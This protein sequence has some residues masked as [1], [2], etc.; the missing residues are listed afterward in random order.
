MATYKE[1]RCEICN[2]IFIPT[3]GNQKVCHKCIPIRKK[4]YISK[5]DKEQHIKKQLSKGLGKPQTCPICGNTF[6][7]LD[8][9]KIYCGSV[10]CE[11]MRCKLKNKRAQ[12]IRNKKRKKE[13]INKLKH[14]LFKTYNTEEFTGIVKIKSPTTHNMMYTQEYVEYCFSKYGYTVLDK[15]KNSGTKMNVICPN[16]HPQKIGFYNFVSRNQRCKKCA[17]ETKVCGTKWE[18]D[19]FK[20]LVKND[21]VFDYR[22]KTVL[23]S[24]KELDFY[25]PKY[26]VAVELCGLYWH[27]ESGGKK[28]RRY[29]KDKQKECIKNNIRLITVFEDEY[30]NFPDVVKSRILHALGVSKQRVYARKTKIEIINNKLARWFLAKHHLQKGSP[31]KFSIG[32]FS[33]EDLVGVMTWGAVSRAHTKVDG[34]PTLE[35]KRFAFIPYLHVVGGASKLFKYSIKYIKNNL[36]EVEFIKSFCDMRYAN[37][38]NTIYRILGFDLYNETDYSPHYIDKSYSTR[39]RNQSLRKTKEEKN[40]NMTEWELRKEQGY[41]RI[42]DCGHRS[43]IL[44]IGTKC[45]YK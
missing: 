28:G 42:W 24:G 23:P 34:L 20:M 31:C 22:T 2:E 37:N 3:S 12:T 7:T 35:L 8:S 6:V 15:Y 16:G 10:E 41:D 33:G 17:L 43:Y 39:I 21:I 45:L 14:F 19:I 27:S 25:I 40:L 9:K 36:K 30:I 44:Y 4:L 13:K 1:K 32:M 18:N 38:K 26:G 11:K 5:Y 29:H